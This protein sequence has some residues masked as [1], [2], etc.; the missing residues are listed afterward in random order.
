MDKELG[1]RVVKV[2]E[3][4]LDTKTEFPLLYKPSHPG[5]GP[6][7]FVKQPNVDRV[8]ESQDMKEAQRSYEANLGVIQNTRTMLQ[9]TLELMR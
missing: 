9:S 3:I 2:G 4:G 1:T 7:G 8:I 5:A 6:D